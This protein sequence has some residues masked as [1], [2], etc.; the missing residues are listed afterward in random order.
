MSSSRK[1]D[2]EYIDKSAILKVRDVKRSD[3]GEYQIHAIN[4]LGEDV[5]SILV[6]IASKTF[7]YF[8]YMIFKRFFLNYRYINM[9]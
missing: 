4:V 2:I 6:T 8:L 3:R 1:Y 9:L 5:A 7:F